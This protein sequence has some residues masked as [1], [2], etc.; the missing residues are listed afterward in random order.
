M[1]N[2]SVSILIKLRLNSLTLSY[3]SFSNVN[4]IVDGSSSA[5]IVTTSSLPAHLR[6]LL[7]FSIESPK[8][9]DLSH[10]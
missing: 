1:P 10:L 8:V 2:Y 4:L 3:F 6:I 7:R 9:R 5:L